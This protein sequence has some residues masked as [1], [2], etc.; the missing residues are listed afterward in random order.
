MK[1]TPQ[2]PT[3]WQ[4]AAA[5][6]VILSLLVCHKLTLCYMQIIGNMEDIF[7]RKYYHKYPFVAGNHLVNKMIRR[8]VTGTT[9]RRNCLDAVV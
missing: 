5:K 4:F 8:L 1:N 7:L 9:S 3:P 2:K 6:E